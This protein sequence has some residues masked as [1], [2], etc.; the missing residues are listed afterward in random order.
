MLDD[1]GE[2][3]YCSIGELSVAVPGH[4]VVGR[5]SALASYF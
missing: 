5:C 1:G 4:V 3:V 2:D